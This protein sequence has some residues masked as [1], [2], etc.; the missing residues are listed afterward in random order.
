MSKLAINNTR[1]KLLNSD[2]NTKQQTKTADEYKEECEKMYNKMCL[3][4]NLYQD[5]LKRDKDLYKEEFQQFITI[6]KPKFYEF[7]E[8][9]S[10]SNEKLCEILKFLAHISHLFPSDLAFVPNELIILLENNYNIIN[11]E[12]RISIIECFNLLRKKNVLDPTIILPLMFKLLSCQDKE[13]RRRVE[14]FIINDLSRINSKVKNNKV[15]KFIKNKCTEM[16][17]LGNNKTNYN[18]GSST[19]N[20]TEN[21]TSQLLDKKAARKTLKITITLFKKGIWGDDKTINIIS[22]GCFSDDDKLCLAACNFFLSEDNITVDDY[23]NKKSNNKDDDDDSSFNEMND[24]KNKFKLLGGA[25]SKKTKKKKMKLKKLMKAVERRETRKSKKKGVVQS[26]FL[27]IN[28]LHD[29]QTLCERMFD[30]L[31]SLKKNKTKTQNLK[32]KLMRL[33]GRLAG[34]NKLIIPNFFAYLCMFISPRQE[35]ISS[36]FAALAEANHQYVL[37][38]DIEP[39]INQV[40]ERFIDVSFPPLYNTLGVNAVTALVEKNSNCI[41]KKHYE[42]IME[43]FK[44]KNKSVHASIK[45][46]N[47]LVKDVIPDIKNKKYLLQSISK[48]F[49]FHK[50]FLSKKIQKYDKNI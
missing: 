12:I 4:L 28:L 22:N 23:D 17:K 40:F 30:K 31:K 16:L 25:N 34:R 19:Y 9:P 21:Q 5:K 18:T 2:N 3:D 43:L 44:V 8:S 29:P 11:Q 32:Y 24:L 6:F 45:G 47:N 33:I 26:T 13:L 10:K 1:N 46:F 39:V 49:C 42:L 41:E 15:N 50:G 7:L 36:I 35:S 20:N 37:P 14:R 48:D 38:V 27:P